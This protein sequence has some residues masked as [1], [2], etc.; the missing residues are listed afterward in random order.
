MLRAHFPITKKKMKRKAKNDI[1]EWVNA[2]IY[3]DPDEETPTET[4]KP[5]ICLLPSTTNPSPGLKAKRNAYSKLDPII[6]LITSLQDAS[7]VEFPSI[8]IFEASST[9]QGIDIIDTNGF[10]QSRDDDDEPKPKRRKFAKR[11]GAKKINSFIG[12]YGSS[13]GEEAEDKTGMDLLGDY[14]DEG[15][16]VE[17]M[18]PEAL[19]ELVKRAQMIQNAEVNGEE[20]DWGDEDE[21]E[22][23][24]T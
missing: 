17:S 14:S 2:L 19:L 16:D 12:G 4:F 24:A 22:Y 10:V 18:S 5:P 8:E 1:P 13:S 9:L 6:P 11:D 3:P 7:F 20:V 21:E 23:R 15:E